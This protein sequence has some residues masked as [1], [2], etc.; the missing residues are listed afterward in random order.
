MDEQLSFVFIV[1]AAALVG[2]TVP[3]LTSNIKPAPFPKYQ[4]A[5]S[6]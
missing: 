4:W 1:E 6:P 2:L 5:A 3:E